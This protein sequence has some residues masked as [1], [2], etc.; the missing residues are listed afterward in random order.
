M[1]SMLMASPMASL[2]LPAEGIH[3]SVWSG[4]Q[5]VSGAGRKQ[6]PRHGEAI[7]VLLGVLECNKLDADLQKERQEDQGSY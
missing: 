7:I 3:S 4:C 1:C 6:N 2:W 5:G